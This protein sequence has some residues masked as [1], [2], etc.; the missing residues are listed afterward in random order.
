ML[1]MMESFGTTVF[2]IMASSHPNEWFVWGDVPEELVQ[3]IL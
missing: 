1:R 2:D 3:R